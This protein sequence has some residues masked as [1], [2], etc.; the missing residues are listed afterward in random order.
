MRRYDRNAK[1]LAVALAALAG[2]VDAIGFLKLGGYFVSFM[3]G[4]TTRLAVGVVR[5]SGMAT[6]AF[7]LIVS[8]V[9][10]VVAGSLVAEASGARRKSAVL[11]LAAGL[12]FVAVVLGRFRTMGLIVLPAAMGA[13]NA[14]FRRDGEVSIGVTYMTGTLVRLGQNIAAAL[15]GGDPLGWL[16]HFLLWLGLLSGG[17]I[18]SIAFPLV[19]LAG[20]L[21]AAAAYLALAWVAPKAVES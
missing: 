18:G 14:V 3:S 8:F 12:I 20:L 19:G 2:Y 16:P 9:A 13:T 11:V 7:A 6:L 1:A 17:I 21:P 10:G 5:Y 15:R 4:N